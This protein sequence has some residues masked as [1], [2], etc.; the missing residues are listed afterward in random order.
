[1]Y[2]EMRLKNARDVTLRNARGT[3]LR[4]ARGNDIDQ[5]KDYIVQGHR[6]RK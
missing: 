2:V 6:Q 1:M 3:T 4:N 5:R